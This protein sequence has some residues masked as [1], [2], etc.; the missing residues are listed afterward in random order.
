MVFDFDFDDEQLQAYVL[1]KQGIGMEF[2][3]PTLDDTFSRY[4]LISCMQ[5]ALLCVEENWAQRPSMLEV[6]AMLR[7]EYASMPMP[8]RPAFSK[9]FGSTDE[10]N[11]VDIAT[12]SHLLPR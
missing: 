4:K 7:N 8:R 3:D 10:V 11:S 5:V 9:K 2:I 12:I 1:W 6:S